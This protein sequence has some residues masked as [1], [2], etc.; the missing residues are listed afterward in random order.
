M[1]A[2][3]FDVLVMTA[4]L[5]GVDPNKQ[6]PVFEQFRP[7]FE[8][9]QIV[10]GQLQTLFKGPFVLVARC[11]VRREQ[12]ATEIN[13]GHYLLKPLNFAGRHTFEIHALVIQDTQ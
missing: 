1:Q 9:I 3:R 12:D 13:V 2:G 5:P 11:E 10:Q 4:T 8:W 7:R 6:L